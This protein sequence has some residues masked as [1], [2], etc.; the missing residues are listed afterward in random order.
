M[1][2][3][4]T[5]NQTTTAAFTGLA[6]MFTLVGSPIE[7]VSV[8]TSLSTF[9]LED[10]VARVVVNAPDGPTPEIRVAF[11]KAREMGAKSL[12]VK[13]QNAGH[14]QDTQL[15]ELIKSELASLAA[16]YGFVGDRFQLVVCPAVC[17]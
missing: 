15:M 17:E 2:F 8:T 14:I 12:F 6:L 9:S 4:R 1:C 3:D 11:K 5:Q 10:E 16:E 13:L 7:A